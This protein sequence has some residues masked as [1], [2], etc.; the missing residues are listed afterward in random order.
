MVQRREHLRF[1]PETSE[2]VRILGKH[3]RENFERDTPIQFD[4]VA[5]IHLPHP[6][7]ADEL[8]NF[9]DAETTTGRKRHQRCL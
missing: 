4:I 6:A 1:A 7:R 3:I 8:A 2:A 9:I 5:A